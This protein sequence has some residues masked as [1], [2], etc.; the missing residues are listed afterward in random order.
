MP[1]RHTGHTANMMMQ[2]R[3]VRRPLSVVLDDSMSA[4]HSKSEYIRRLL[5]NFR[6]MFITTLDNT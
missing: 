4:K 6:D 1:N 2:G 3:E 5:Q